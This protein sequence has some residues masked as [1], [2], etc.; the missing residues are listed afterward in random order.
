MEGIRDKESKEKAFR[1]KEDEEKMRVKNVAYS[2]L[3][4]GIALV[5][6]PYVLHHVRKEIN[7]ALMANFDRQMKFA[8]AM[9]FTFTVIFMLILWQM[10]V[11]K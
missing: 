8:F 1:E 5:M 7:P 9:S 4:V 10:G 6:F 3:S 2:V 11:F